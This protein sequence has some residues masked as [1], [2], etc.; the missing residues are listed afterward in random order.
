LPR[1]PGGRRSILSSSISSG[2]DINP[3]PNASTA[4]AT[5][6]NFRQSA[7]RNDEQ[8]NLLAVAPHFG[9][10][11]DAAEAA[12]VPFTFVAV[13]VNVYEVPFVRPVTVQLV[14]TVVQV[15]EPGDDVTV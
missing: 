11:P 13:T 3:H 6:V 4:R 15:N 10:R 5:S 2:F 9:L 7:D 14:V 12:P 1:A 8:H